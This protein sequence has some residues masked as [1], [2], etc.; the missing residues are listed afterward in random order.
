MA[1]GTFADPRGIE[2]GT[3]QKHIARGVI[4]AGAASAQH[5]GNAHGL[6]GVADGEVTLR[7]FVFR[8]V[9]GDEGGTLRHGA[10]HDF[11]AFYHV[12]IEAVEGLAVCHHD[13]VGDVDDVV[14]GT[15]ADGFE[16]FLQPLRTFLHLASLDGD[17]AVTRTGFGGL[18]VD[19]DVKVVVVDSKA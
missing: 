17:G 4:R 3:F 1:A 8:S 14:D 5:A 6:A 16:F 10:H 13:V 19:G 11:P 9:K 12:G 18:H 15:Q 2:I 7:E